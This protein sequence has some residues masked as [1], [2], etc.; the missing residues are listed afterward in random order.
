MRRKLLD[1]LRGSLEVFGI[2]AVVAI[3]AFWCFPGALR[4]LGVSDAIQRAAS[5]AAV[6]PSAPPLSPADLAA[7]LLAVATI[8]LATVAFFLSIGAFIGFSELRATARETS[9]E[10]IKK[11]Y[12]MLFE[13]MRKDKQELSLLRA[14][15]TVDIEDLMERVREELSQAGG[16]PS[17]QEADAFAQASSIAETQNRI[18]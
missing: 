18:D 3:I 4:G 8:V 14:K 2:G 1:A 17:G 15:L 11:A 7:I 9:A 13:E 6:A 5:Q 16:L 12:A 10:E